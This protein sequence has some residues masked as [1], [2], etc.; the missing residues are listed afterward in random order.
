[1]GPIIF[2]RAL[3]ID[4]FSLCTVLIFNC[5][6]KRNAVSSQSPFQE[7][8]HLLDC[9]FCKGKTDSKIHNLHA[10][11]HGSNIKRKTT[12]LQSQVAVT[13]FSPYSRL[14]RQAK[15]TRTGFRA[16]GSEKEADSVANS[17]RTFIQQLLGSCFSWGTEGTPRPRHHHEALADR[18]LFRATLST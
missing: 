14:H 7:N 17:H 4:L 12:G 18:S 6:V 16:Q 2:D 15:S 10:A 5:N 13:I 11:A 9:S 1:M 8:R 3:S